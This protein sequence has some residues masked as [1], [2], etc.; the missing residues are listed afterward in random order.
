MRNLFSSF[1]KNL[2]LVDRLAGELRDALGMPR[3]MMGSLR[4]DLERMFLGFGGGFDPERKDP[5]PEVKELYQAKARGVEPYN[6]K[7]LEI[8]NKQA[9]VQW[10]YGSTIKNSYTTVESSLAGPARGHLR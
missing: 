2:S 4:R 1:W 8:A 6:A 9:V 7:V 10:G 5:V 3:Q